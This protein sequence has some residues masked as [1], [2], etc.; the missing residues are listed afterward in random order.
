MR[1]ADRFFPS[2]LASFSTM[3]R[4]V[5]RCFVRMPAWITVGSEYTDE[6][7]AFVRDISTRGIFFYSDFRPTPGQ[8]ISL[9][10]EYLKGTN[11]VRLHLSGKVVRLE[12]S[13]TDAAVGTAVRFDAVQPNVPRTPIRAV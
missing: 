5:P 4:S 3:Q 13:A 10:L 9:V 6:H 8:S 2:H 12:E 11:R 7:V 1:L